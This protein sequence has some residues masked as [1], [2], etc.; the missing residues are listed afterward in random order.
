MVYDISD[1]LPIRQQFNVKLDKV[2]IFHF[3]LSSNIDGGQDSSVAHY[4]LGVVSGIGLKQAPRS[5][6]LEW[7]QTTTK[8]PNQWIRVKI[9]HGC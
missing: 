3:K 6:L 5:K 4:S 9:I 7:V 8:K 2:Y 1:V